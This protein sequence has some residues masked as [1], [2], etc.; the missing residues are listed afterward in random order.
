M[1]GSS[2]ALKTMK[3]YRKLVVKKKN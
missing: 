1:E 2:F 3:M